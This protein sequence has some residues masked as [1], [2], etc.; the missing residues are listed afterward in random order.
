LAETLGL[1]ENLWSLY[2]YQQEN[3]TEWPIKN[4]EKDHDLWER[5]TFGLKEIISKVALGWKNNKTTLE[6][7]SDEY[8][9]ELLKITVKKHLIKKYF[10]GFEDKINLKVMRNE[11]SF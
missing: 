2:T 10:Y 11:L 4:L 1:N 3:F 9:G 5:T 7:F 6:N 8:S